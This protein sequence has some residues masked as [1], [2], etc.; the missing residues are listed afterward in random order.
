MDM[1]ELEVIEN[2]INHGSDDNVF[3]FRRMHLASGATTTVV[4][5]ELHNDMRR[6]LANIGSGI[7]LSIYLCHNALP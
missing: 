7:T 4:V 3:A 6:L 1:A 2:L 5:G